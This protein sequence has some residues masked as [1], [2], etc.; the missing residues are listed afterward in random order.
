M[1]GI[2]TITDI[3][4]GTQ[5]GYRDLSQ[6]AEHLGIAITSLKALLAEGD[7]HIAGTK[8]VGTL[9]L[10]KSRRGGNRKK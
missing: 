9:N 5:D 3:S 4:K 10:V 8:I 7:V 1:S 6:V 2:I